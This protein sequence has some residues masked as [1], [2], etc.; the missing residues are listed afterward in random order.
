MAGAG[1]VQTQEDLVPP[2]PAAIGYRLAGVLLAPAVAATLH[3]ILAGPF[4]IDLL[5][6]ESPGSSTL[7]TLPL[8]QT[9]VATIIISV[10][11]WISVMALERFLGGEKGRRI[12][13]LIAVGVFVVS[14]GPIIPLDVSIAVK[15]GLFVLHFGVAMILIPTLSNGTRAEPLHRDV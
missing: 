3:I 11:G 2:P 7:A 9:T 12:W 4:G 15:W 10:L 5:V 13:T 6:P 14:L 8:I 1:P